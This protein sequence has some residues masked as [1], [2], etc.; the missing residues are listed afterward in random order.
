MTTT[1][2]IHC[3]LDTN[4]HQSQDEARE[5]ILQLAAEAFPQGHTIIE[6]L[7]RWMKADGE[8][9]TEPTIVVEWMAT[10]QQKANGEAHVRVNRLAGAYKEQAYQEAV[11]VTTHET[12][13]VFV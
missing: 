1:Y 8:V 2:R 11:M 7:G 3:G 5:L 6:T 13:A 12:Y 9:V 4:G 10:D